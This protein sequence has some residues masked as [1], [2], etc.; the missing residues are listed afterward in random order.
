MF[1]GLLAEINLSEFFT[2]TINWM[3][4]PFR[5]HLGIYIWPAI[6]AST[7]AFVYV[8]TKNIGST[9]ASILLIFGLFGSVSEFIVVPEFRLFFSFIAA[10]GLAGIIL[11]LYMKKHG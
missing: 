4:T 11:S 1:N 8:S 10:A 6:F 2:D 9:I 3:L 7:V 5:S